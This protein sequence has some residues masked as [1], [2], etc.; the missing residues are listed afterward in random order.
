MAPPG[1]WRKLTCPP[2][3][4]LPSPHPTLPGSLA[5]TARG[6]GA[7]GL[8]THTRTRHGTHGVFDAASRPPPTHLP[9]GR[10]CELHSADEAGEAGELEQ[11]PLSHGTPRL[12][13]GSFRL[14]IIS[15]AHPTVK[16]GVPSGGHLLPGEQGRLLAKVLLPT[17]DVGSPASL[18]LGQGYADAQTVQ[19]PQTGHVQPISSVKKKEMI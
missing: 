11:L 9:R 14:R 19:P 3:P 8:Q 4:T 16:T 7:G 18:S 2:D 15:E 1:W 10:R 5:G 17:S 13:S 12:Q 6:R